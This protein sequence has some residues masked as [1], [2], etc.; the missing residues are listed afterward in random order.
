MNS[1][2][3]NSTSKINSIYNFLNPISKLSEI[4]A[5]EALW[6]KQGAS[7]KSISQLF[8]DNPNKLPSE[9]V[10]PNEIDRYKNYFQS[11]LEKYNVSTFGIAINKIDEFPSKLHNKIKYPLEVL[12]YRGCWDLIN[13]KCISVVGT[14]KPSTDGIKRTIKLVKNLVQDGFTIVSGLATGIDTVAHNT[15]LEYGGKTIGVIGTPLTHQ[16][17]RENANLQETIANKF[18]LISQVPFCR[19][20]HQNINMNRLFFPERNITMSAL[21]LGTIIVEAGETSGTLIQARA[22]LSQERKLFILDNCFRN[23]QLTWPS[24]YEKKGAIRVKEYSDIIN[25]LNG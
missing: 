8:K 3:L 4:G 16:Y 13:A 23:S 18:L 19:Y 14:R 17:P 11:L 6:D 5:Y 12:Y 10:E 15:A 20:E 24:K 7:F 2:S 9:F 1:E 22:A 21:S 25:V